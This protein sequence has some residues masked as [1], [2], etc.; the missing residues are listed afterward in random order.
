MIASPSRWLPLLMPFSVFAADLPKPEA[1][2]VVPGF[3]D[4]LVLRGGGRV[5]TREQWA[6]ERAPELRELFQH[7]EYGFFPPKPAKVTA[8]IE[9]EDAEALGGKAHLKEVALSW[10]MPGV[11]IHLLLVTPKGAKP[12]PVFLGLNF[13]GNHLALADP[14]VRL[15]EAWVRRSEK[16]SNRASDADRGKEEDVWNIRMAVE[17][18]YGIATFYNGDVVPDNAE[19]A[20]E[21]LKL[22]RPA[23]RADAPAANDCATIAAWAWGL[24]RA[25]DYLVT[26]PAVEGKRVAVVGHSRNGKTALLAGAFDERFALVIPSQA[27]CGGTAPCRVPQELSALQANGRPTVETVA[28]IN[29]AFPHWFCGNFKAFN[30]EPARLPFDQHELIALCAP[31][32]VLVSAATEDL[33]ANPAG[34]FEMLRGA[35]PVYRLVSGEGLDATQ[36]PEPSKLLPGRLGYFLRPG[37]HAMSPPDWTAWLDYADRWL[38]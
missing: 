33:W 28:K 22:F 16:G 30:A 18:G 13:N 23:E 1:L 34:Q 26:D 37:K 11:T 38:R 2:P 35:D 8:V 31:R 32:P 14:K 27:G 20:N 10:G 5:A 15:P 24:S 21:R 4:A 17:R 25:L 29:A 7:Y 36:Q 12:A 3:P 6:A 19:L 9:R